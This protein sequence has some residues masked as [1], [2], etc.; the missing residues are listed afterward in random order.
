MPRLARIPGAAMRKR[1]DCDA[2]KRM[3]T[4][5]LRLRGLT[6]TFLQDGDNDLTF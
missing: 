1:L 5:E 3:E 6:R 4:R 2:P